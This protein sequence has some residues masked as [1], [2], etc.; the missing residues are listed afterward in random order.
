MSDPIK[1]SMP[2][3]AAGVRFPD[4]AL[5]REATDLAREV[6][7]PVLFNHLMRTYLFGELL[8]RQSFGSY[9]SELFYLGAVLHDL[10]AT[11]RFNG[12]ERFEIDGA[13]AARDFLQQRGLPEEKT[14]IVWDAIALHTSLGIPIRKQPEIALVQVGSGLDVI[15]LRI[16]ELPYGALDQI[17]AAY[18]RLGL[19]K[20]FPPALAEV[21]AKKLQTTLGNIAADIAARHI[22]GFKPV[23]FCDLMDAAPFSE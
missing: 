21:V 15:G 7:T 17:L 11:E 3:E 22:P 9:D 2:R 14:E 16:E 23:N 10:G 6:S 12:A 18:P 1:H 13:N 8:G 20:A 5:A 4:S 19:K